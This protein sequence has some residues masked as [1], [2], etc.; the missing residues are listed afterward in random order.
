MVNDK[1]NR[2]VTVALMAT[3]QAV[4]DRHIAEGADIDRN[5]TMLEVQTET[6]R[7]VDEIFKIVGPDDLI[8]VA[9]C[10]RYRIEEEV[11]AFQTTRGYQKPLLQGKDGRGSRLKPTIPRTAI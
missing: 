6:Q 9:S 4:I 1:T 7:L 5:L 3:K 2:K 11:Y 8:Y 10:R